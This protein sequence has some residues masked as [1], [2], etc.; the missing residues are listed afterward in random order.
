MFAARVEERANRDRAVLGGFGMVAG[1]RS[2][3]LGGGSGDMWLYIL[4]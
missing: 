1:V 4:P 2:V 3:W